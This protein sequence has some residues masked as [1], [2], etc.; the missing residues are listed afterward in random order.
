MSSSAAFL[1]SRSFLFFSAS[2]FFYLFSSA[3]FFFF[4]SSAAFFS[5]NSCFFLSASSFFLSATAYLSS[6]FLVSSTLGGFLLVVAA[7]GVLSDLTE[8]SP[9]AGLTL[10]AGLVEVIPPAFPVVGLGVDLVDV[11]VSS[12]CCFNYCSNI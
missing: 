11:L 4:S 5:S 1:S 7:V 9:G 10:S 6:S 8:E 2:S 3:A 12:S